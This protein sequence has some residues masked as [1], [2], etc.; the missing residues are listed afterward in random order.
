MTQIKQAFI[1]FL[2]TRKDFGQRNVKPQIIIISE[3]TR[4]KKYDKVVRSVGTRRQGKDDDDH[5]SFP[6]VRLGVPTAF[7]GVAPTP[8]VALVKVNLL[9][10][11]PPTSFTLCTSLTARLAWSPICAGGR[12]AS[13]RD[14]ARRR[15]CGSRAWRLGLGREEAR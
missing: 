6:G 11:T 7:L 4:N 13:K 15:P 12:S 2:L 10:P 3:V 5:R 14:K 8:V 1:S 9:S